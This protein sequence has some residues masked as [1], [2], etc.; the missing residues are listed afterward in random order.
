MA[1][2]KK[3][4]LAY[5]APKA[6]HEPFNPAPWYADYWD[7]SWPAREPI[8]ENWNCSFESRK[9]HHGVIA[10]EQ[11][12]TEQASKVITGMFKNRW[13]TLMSV[14]DLISDVI[15]T[16][17]DL[18]LLD[19]TYF[20]YST[21]H[22]F[23]LGQFNLLMDKRHVYEWDTKIHLLARGPGIMPGSS[24]KEPGTQV[25]I[26]PTLLG[27]AG[28]AA[29][30]QM[31]GRSIV[32]FLVQAEAE[33]LLESTK[34]HLASLGD[35]HAYRSGW[36]QE[37]FIEMYF[38]S[39]NVKCTSG[40]HGGRYPHRDSLCANVVNNTDCW[41]PIKWDGKSGLPTGCYPTEDAT[42]N[43]IAIRELG[44]KNTLY[45]EFQ[46][47]DLATGS[48]DFSR[49]DFVEYY[50]LAVDPWEMR[51]LFSS[52]PAAVLSPLHSRLHRWA[53][54]AGPS[55]DPNL[56]SPAPQLEEIVV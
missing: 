1:K 11:M 41:C 43:F 48:V 27:L 16:V 30:S 12:I 5:I 47:G 29:P 21:D 18:G 34:Q 35:A 32:P 36:R 6:A 55:C 50:D 2:K 28:L 49:T 45:A 23:Q 22:G 7:P 26:A 4:F 56:W 46:T 20:F 8:T 13:R 19:S 25:D 31:D 53:A 15:W 38:V 9:N 42:N 24:F 3:P 14:D 17:Y 44:G 54:C 33:D 52:T 10:T 51:N 39:Y 40:C 37:V